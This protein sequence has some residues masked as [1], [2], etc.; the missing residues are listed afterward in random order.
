VVADRN[1][2]GGVSRYTSAFIVFHIILLP[3]EYIDFPFP[4]LDNACSAKLGYPR[5]KFFLSLYQNAT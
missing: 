1:V 3:G 5:S 2:M 4:S